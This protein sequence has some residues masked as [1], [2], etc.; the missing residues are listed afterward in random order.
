MRKQFAIAAVCLGCVAL[1][2]WGST[3]FVELY[4][5]RRFTMEQFDS[6]QSGLTPSEVESILRRKWGDYTSGPK[7]YV[8]DLRGLTKDCDFD[9]PESEPLFG[10]KW[11]ANFDGPPFP[12]NPN[13]RATVE[14][15]IWFDSHDRVTGKQFRHF[16]YVTPPPK[17]FSD[18]LKE[19][20]GRWFP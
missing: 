8:E 12:V 1:L 11:I 17:S 5:P 7:R 10:L 3:A 13:E 14:I 15:W 20:V 4:G 18:T 19:C 9:L 2:L 6:I 16:M